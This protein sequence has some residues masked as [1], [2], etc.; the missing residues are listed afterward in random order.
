MKSGQIPDDVHDIIIVG[1][2]PGGLTAGQY[3]S[4]AGLNVLLIEGSSTFSQVTVTDL[5][6]NYPGI[7]EPAGGLELIERF[8]KQANR[9]GLG[10]ISE[11]VT[12][13]TK[14]QLG[15]PQFIEGWEVK[16]NSNTYHCLSIIIA[17]G[18]SWKKLCIPG[19]ETF[20][21]RGI[22][23]CATCDGPFYKN[24]D[25]VVIGGGDT[26]IQ[27]AIYLTKFARK[28]TIVHRRDRLR[29][30]G[31]LQERA[32]ANDRIDFAWNSVPEEILGDDFV[33]GVKI[34]N[35][36]APG[37]SS[38]IQADGV[39]VFVGLEPNTNI[40]RGI[41]RLDDNGY[42]LADSDMKT[43][44]SGMFACGDCI[45]KLLRQIV[46]ACGDGATAA[47]SAKLHVEAL[48]GETYGDFN[49]EGG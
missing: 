39:F 9:F 45:K 4:R 5:I 46:T 33:T 30:T 14:R 23:T 48:K 1:G 49:L 34:K 12:S 8:K 17:T 37:K 44:E 28:I 3:A 24:R 15:N 2:G 36:K 43:S 21:G 35:V 18:A 41:V 11:D 40:V 26:A 32:L 31:F 13:I 47:F 16:T 42:I 22:S 20:S 38:V 10:I 7:P 6:E 19:E 29:A 25:V 27:E